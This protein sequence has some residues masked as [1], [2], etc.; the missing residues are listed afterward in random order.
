MSG[1]PPASVCR[2][3][4]EKTAAKNGQRQADCLAERHLHPVSAAA[5][6]AGPGLLLPRQLVW[7]GCHLPVFSGKT[8]VGT[9]V[10]QVRL[11]LGLECF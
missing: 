4:L 3:L 8:D 1:E 9:G 7:R 10:F 5:H 2:H 6:A 11:T